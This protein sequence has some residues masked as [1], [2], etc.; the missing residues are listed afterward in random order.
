MKTTE[1]RLRMK[2]YPSMKVVSVPPGTPVIPATDLP[3][4]GWWVEPWEGMNENERA[5][6]GERIWISE[7]ERT[8]G[9]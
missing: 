5:I 3:R 6:V 9:I 1:K 4:G 8:E 2:F 7:E